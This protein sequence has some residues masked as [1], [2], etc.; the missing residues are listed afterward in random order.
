MN[1]NQRSQLL[2]YYQHDRQEILSTYQPFLPFLKENTKWRLENNQNYQNF[3]KEIEKKEFASEP[4][5]FFGQAD[6]QF[7][8]TLNVMKD[9]IIMIEEEKRSPNYTQEN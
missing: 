8:E 1:P 4:V 5:E 9:L 6:L 3:L 2:S 7:A